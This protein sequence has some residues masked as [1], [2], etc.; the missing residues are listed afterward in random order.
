MAYLN[1]MSGTTV[2]VVAVALLALIGLSAAASS[3]AAASAKSVA[4]DS[5]AGG[6]KHKRMRAFVQ[7]D[8]AKRLGGRYFNAEDTYGLDKRPGGARFFPSS[9]MDSFYNDK[10]GGGRSFNAPAWADRFKRPRAF[11]R[12]SYSSNYYGGYGASN[13]RRNDPDFWQF[14]KKKMRS[15]S[16][17]EEYNYDD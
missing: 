6:Q 5:D 12:P 4:A 14:R 10:R 11:Y 1:S 8:Y 15:F 13:Y 16:L 17:P 9:G 3:A 7:P 2:N